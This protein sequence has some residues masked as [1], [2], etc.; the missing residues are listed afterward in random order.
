[1][2]LR[3]NFHIIICDFIYTIKK[4]VGM[5]KWLNFHIIICNFIYTIKKVLKM[6]P[7]MRGAGNINILKIFINKI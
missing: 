5:A 2:A 7:I 1:M 6:P 4:G 3:L